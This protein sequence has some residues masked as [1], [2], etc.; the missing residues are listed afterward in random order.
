MAPPPAIHGP[1]VPGKPAQAQRVQVRAP[2]Y[3]QG[4]PQ[5]GVNVKPNVS[6][7]GRFNMQRGMSQ[8]GQQAATQR[9]STLGGMNITNK[10]GYGVEKATN[11]TMKGLLPKIAQAVP[12]AVSTVAKGA[13]RMAGGP[14]GALLGSTGPA[15]AG[16]NEKARQAAYG[17]SLPNVAPGQ[18]SAKNVGTVKG[19]SIGADVGRTTTSK[20][21]ETPNTNASGYYKGSAVGD[22]TTKQ[23]D[24][25]SG[26]AKRT[27]Q[28][29]A[30]LAKMNKISDVNKLSAGA[31]LMTKS[32]TPP[33]RPDT[34]AP[35]APAPAAQS[36]AP[37][38]VPTAD[39]VKSQYGSP[40]DLNKDIASKAKETRP[41]PKVAPM[42]STESSGKFS[43]RALEEDDDP[44]LT[45]PSQG[46]GEGRRV[47]QGAT[48][49][50]GSGSDGSSGP[51][52]AET[53]SKTTPKSLKENFVIV[54]STKYRIV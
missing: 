15:G 31:K 26:I 33:V 49:G 5:T 6:T 7:S 47:K 42:G 21:K 17:Q 54:G 36:P 16:E 2:T 43:N 24:T 35:A 30:D 27:G 12:G 23:G 18:G 8:A 4:A 46:A 38:P 20:P 45:T 3:S 1:A 25:L 52:N 28:S 53:L 34:P 37:A 50:D 48:P 14:L 13:G 11:S 39:Q 10:I 29:V 44:K 41:T 22:Y 19:G 40:E 9:A 32:V 51:D